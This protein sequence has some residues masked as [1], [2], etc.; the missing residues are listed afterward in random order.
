MYYKS[1][2]VANKKQTSV[3]KKTCKLPAV[4]N[5]DM[6]KYVS[7]HCDQVNL[8]RKKFQP[9]SNLNKKG[10]KHCKISKKSNNKK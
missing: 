5:M 8:S 2:V 7:L 3:W 4:V 9:T 6:E 10:I 1:S